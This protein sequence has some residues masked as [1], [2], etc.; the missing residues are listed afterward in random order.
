MIR[1]LLN[2]IK[3]KRNPGFPMEKK[4]YWYC[5]K[6]YSFRH[7]ECS[8]MTRV[9]FEG[10]DLPFNRK[11]MFDPWIMGLA[12]GGDDTSGL[13][14]GLIPAIRAGEYV[15]LYEVVKNH[16]P[17]RGYEGAGWDD[18]RK[19]D[20][21]FVKKVHIPTKTTGEKDEKV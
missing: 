21:R 2:F 4:G 15:G 11:V 12:G 1:A 17:E 14:E 6:Y 13:V 3:S 20:L 10:L 5:G 18:G 16:P 7:N 8:H 19:V 9:E